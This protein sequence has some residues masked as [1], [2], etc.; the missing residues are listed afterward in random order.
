MIGSLSMS[1]RYEVSRSICFHLSS[2]CFHEGRSGLL[3]GNFFPL[4]SSAFAVQL[5]IFEAKPYT[6]NCFVNQK[7]VF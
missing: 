1:R 2:M 7:K 6:K 5:N 4:K 3:S